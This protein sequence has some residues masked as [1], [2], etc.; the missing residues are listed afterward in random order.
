MNRARPRSQG[1]HKAFN[2]FAADTYRYVPGDTPE[3]LP[4]VDRYRAAIPIGALLQS[5]Q[6][7]ARVETPSVSHPSP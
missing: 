7:G 6:K 2:A 4:F 3:G 5:H 1:S